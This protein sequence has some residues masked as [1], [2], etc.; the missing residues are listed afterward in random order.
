MSVPRLIE[1]GMKYFLD[2]SLK[3]CNNTKKTYNNNFINISLFI[4]FIVLVG[5]LLYYRKKNKEK[6]K[7]EKEL[8]EEEAKLEIYNTVKKVNE[9][10]YRDKG[11]LITEIPKFE[12]NAFEGTMKNLELQNKEM[13]ELFP[14]NDNISS[15][16]KLPNMIVP[17]QLEAINFNNTFENNF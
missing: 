15:I 2:E 4:G 6:F 14:R 16:D 9:E 3:I 5:W 17:N 13:N 1:P 11:N 10:Q 8:K 12:E 7:R